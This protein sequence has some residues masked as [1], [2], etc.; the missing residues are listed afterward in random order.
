M[1]KL[2][3]LAI[4]GLTAVGSLSAAP[5]YVIKDGELQNGIIEMEYGAKVTAF[6]HFEYGVAGPDGEKTAVYKHEDSFKEVRFDLTKATSMP[7]AKT[8]W[9]MGVEYAISEEFVA[10]AE[11]DTYGVF[12]GKKPNIQIGVFSPSLMEEDEPTIANDK[13]EGFVAVDAKFALDGSGDYMASNTYFTAKKELYINPNSFD[14]VGVMIFSFLREYAGVCTPGYIKNLW[15]EESGSARPFYAEDFQGVG[16]A[17]FATYSSATLKNLAATSFAGGYAFTSDGAVKTGRVW[18][19]DGKDAPYFD[20]EYTLTLDVPTFA[21]AK[22]DEL[23][24][25]NIMIENIALPANASKI[26]TSALVKWVYSEK[27]QEAFDAATLAERRIPATLTFNDAVATSV[28]MFPGDSI[29]YNWENK[30]SIIDVPAG[31]TTVSISFQHGDFE[32]YV[33][34]LVLSAE[35][36]VGNEE[37]VAEANAFDVVVYPNP[38]TDVINVLNAS[39]VEIVNLTG[40]VVA[41]ANGSQ[42]NVSA[43]PA[44]LYLVKANVNG[45]VVVK[46]VIKK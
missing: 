22:A 31:A 45:K 14:Q 37:V 39:K 6:D 43:L 8:H 29:N 19:E 44:G 30:K 46:T 38:A 4:A 27:L 33:D 15:F 21:D 9:I 40:N 3:L 23:K 13:A 41:T 42:I 11:D 10:N 36:N 24:P 26:Y 28:E 1:K 32:Y 20:S 34:N 7:S 2:G 12:D 35:P 17:R 25:K 18:Q 5:Y 16:G